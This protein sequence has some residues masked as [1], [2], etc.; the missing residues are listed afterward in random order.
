M[1]DNFEHNKHRNTVLKSVLNDV[2]GLA[3]IIKKV[4]Y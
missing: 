2:Y 1:T 3:T 4:S